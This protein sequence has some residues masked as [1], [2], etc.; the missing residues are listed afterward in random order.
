MPAFE[1][2][3]PPVRC[4][5]PCLTGVKRMAGQSAD[6]PAGFSSCV[7]PA[8]MAIAHEEGRDAM[9][10]RPQ[11]KPA[12]GGKVISAGLVRQEAGDCGKRGVGKP[13]LKRPKHIDRLA[14]LHLNH[15]VRVEP[16]RC[17][18][19][20]VKRGLTIGHMVRHHP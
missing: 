9:T 2:L 17:K 3:K 19:G 15:S 12:A 6:R 20:W 14:R 11:A 13:F 5:R 8:G 1:K 16:E 10:C 4:A 7:F 18:S